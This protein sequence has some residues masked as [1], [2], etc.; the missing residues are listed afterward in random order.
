MLSII[1]RD[2]GSS[3]QL[4]RFADNN[5]VLQRKALADLAEALT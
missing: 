2:G 1:R 3:M 5:R 4:P